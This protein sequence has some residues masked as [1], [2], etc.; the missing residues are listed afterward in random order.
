MT[1]RQPPFDYWVDSHCHLDFADFAEDGVQALIDRARLNRVGAMLTISTHISRLDRY[2]ALADQFDNVW[3]TIGVHPLQ[4]H[5]E[6]ERDVTAAQLIAMAN[7]HPKIVALG[8]CGLDYHYQRETKD[9]Q[10]QVF[11]AHIEA[12]I[13]TGLPI[14]I[15]AR[16]ADDDMIA[17]LSEYEGKGLKAVM[18]CF[19]SSKELADFALK[20]GFYISFSGILTFP[21]ANVLHEVCQSTSLDRLLVETDAPY[22]APV[23]YRGKRNEPAY[24]SHTGRFLAK[25]HA[26]D[27][28]I[29]MNA[30]TENFYKL[31][32]KISG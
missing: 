16:D 11:R 15:H 27:E 2:T 10:Q 5:E 19:S 23:P 4:A 3:T 30:T 29:A 1:L 21:K 17:L 14:I 26:I 31:F 32:N 25:L 24:V 12:G 8:E 22:L 28:S 9:I 13:A 6:G 18:H 7:S 20:M